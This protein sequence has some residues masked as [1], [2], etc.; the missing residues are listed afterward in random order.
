MVSRQPL[1][2]DRL[3]KWRSES[4]DLKRELKALGIGWQPRPER[5][6]LANLLASEQAVK[7]L[8]DDSRGSR[9]RSGTKEQIKTGRNY[10]TVDSLD[11]KKQD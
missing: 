2:L 3:Q 5:G 4:N 6:W 7:P 11:N 1:Y 8:L 9:R 10:L